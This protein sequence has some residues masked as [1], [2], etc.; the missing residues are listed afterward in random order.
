MRPS[1]P[2]FLKSSYP[3]QAWTHWLADTH[4]WR[5]ADTRKGSIIMHVL[6]DQRVDRHVFR[7]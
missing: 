6:I 3:R 4:V 7:V 1:V 5:S 2:T